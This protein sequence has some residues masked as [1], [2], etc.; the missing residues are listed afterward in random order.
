MPT[1]NKKK[2]KTW[3]RTEFAFPSADQCTCYRHKTK[4]G[5][6]K[7]CSQKDCVIALSDPDNPSAGLLKMF[8]LDCWLTC[9]DE[10]TVIDPYQKRM[11]EQQRKEGMTLMNM[12]C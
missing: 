2:P 5:N 6:N 1:T 12:G 4:T 9:R 3:H 10:K 8:C 7:R 11:W